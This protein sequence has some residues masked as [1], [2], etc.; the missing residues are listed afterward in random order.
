MSEEKKPTR[1]APLTL[2]EQGA[3]LLARA[4]SLPQTGAAVEAAALRRVEALDLPPQV[5]TLLARFVRGAGARALVVSQLVGIWI[6]GVALVAACIV[7]NVL[8]YRANTY[9]SLAVNSTALAATG[10]SGPLSQ[11]PTPAPYVTPT[12]SPAVAAT[13]TF[14]AQTGGFIPPSLPSPLPVGTPIPPPSV[15]EILASTAR[16]TAIPE[17]TLAPRT[18]V[19]PPGSG[20][21][22]QIYRVVSQSPSPNVEIETALQDARFFRLAVRYTAPDDNTPARLFLPGDPD[23]FFIVSQGVKYTIFSASG[24]ELGQSRAMRAGEVLMITLHFDP[25]PDPTQPFDLIEG[26]HTGEKGVRY[27]DVFNIRLEPSP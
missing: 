1:P 19:L 10:A 26:E 12:F 24:L 14:L 18:T 15:A 8:V 27:W 4:R 11:L 6:L 9:Y 20:S 25:L 16:P 2:R 7:A 23:A 17:P 3:R 22:S 21:D 13:A 5:T